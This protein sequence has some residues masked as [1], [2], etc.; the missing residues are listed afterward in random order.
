M[1]ASSR[2]SSAGLVKQAPSKTEEQV[3]SRDRSLGHVPS[4]LAWPSH[5]TSEVPMSKLR[6]CSLSGHTAFSSQNQQYNMR[7]ASTPQHLDRMKSRVSR[8]PWPDKIKSKERVGDR[9]MV[10]SILSMS[11]HRELT[12]TGEVRHQRPHPARHNVPSNPS[13]WLSSAFDLRM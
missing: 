11:V 13:S 5:P 12:T 7:R 9:K 10:T 1:A 4:F 8:E 3:T 6:S 2:D